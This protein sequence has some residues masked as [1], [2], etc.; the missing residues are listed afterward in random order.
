[1]KSKWWMF[2][3][4]FVAACSSDG[5]DAEGNDF[6]IA[7]TPLSGKV[8]GKAWTF[9]SGA[10]DGFL[11]QGESSWFTTLY[12]D[13]VATCGG[14]PSSTQP[15][16]LIELPRQPGTYSLSVSQ[17]ATFAIS[18]SGSDTENLVA[19]KGKLTISEVTATS[20]KGG[21]HI[22]YDANNTVNGQFGAMVCPE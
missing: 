16:I 18:R 9:V 19:T 6:T 1:M 4:L 14:V 8:D 11:S 20:V 3:L 15:E 21:A 2:G 7:S 13:S 22:E 5:G 17:N 10:T 12:A